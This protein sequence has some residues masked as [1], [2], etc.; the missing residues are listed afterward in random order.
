VRLLETTKNEI[1]E[2][3]KRNIT[4]LFEEV[5]DPFADEFDIT[6]NHQEESPVV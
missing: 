1:I 6:S 4:N 3:V 2:I 5:D